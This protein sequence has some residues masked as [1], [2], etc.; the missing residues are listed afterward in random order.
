MVAKGWKSGTMQQKEETALR[1]TKLGKGQCLIE[2]GKMA[3]R[4]EEG[5]FYGTTAVY[6]IASIEEVVELY[7][8]MQERRGTLTEKATQIFKEELIKF[9]AMGG[10]V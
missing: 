7:E 3:R 6:K 8:Q 4:D 2:V 1:I 10:A 5:E 9:L